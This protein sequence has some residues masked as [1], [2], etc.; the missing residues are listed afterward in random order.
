MNIGEIL[1][2]LVL[3]IIF[4]VT[5]AVLIYRIGQSGL[6]DLNSGSKYNSKE[7]PDA[8]FVRG[9]KGSLIFI[10]T[11]V[12]CVFI[13]AQL[14]GNDESTYLFTKFAMLFPLIIVIPFAI[15]YLSGVYSAYLAAKNRVRDASND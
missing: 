8:V 15:A 12:I 13:L 4:I 7:S 14:A 5:P 6:N 1:L 9:T 11:Y 2:Y 3:G 10:A